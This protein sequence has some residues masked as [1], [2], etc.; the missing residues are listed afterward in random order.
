MKT[1]MAVAIAFV[2]L[3][4]LPFVAQPAAAG[5]IAIP[6]DT[7]VVET[8]TTA[9]YDGG[10]WVHVRIGDVSLGVIWSTNASLRRGP[11]LFLDYARFFGA[12]ELYDEQG[13]YLGTRALPMHTVLMQHF[14]KMV[15]FVDVDG[16][17]LFDLHIENRTYTSGD[18]PVKVLDLNTAWALDG[19]IEQVV[20]NTSAWVSFTIRATNVSYRAVWDD[21]LHAWRP[22]TPSDGALD[23]VSL[24]FRLAATARD[25]I[26][27]VPVY[28]VTLANGD[29]RRTPTHS[30]FLENRT[31]AGRSV[32]IDGKYDQR[33]EGWDFTG[34]PDAKLAM[35]TPLSFGNFYGTLIVQWLQQQFG[36]ACLKDGTFEHCESDAG[37]TIPVRIA[38]DRLRVAEG[39]QRTT[40][41][42]E[43]Y[44]TSDVTVDGTPAT[45]T[46]EIY[47]AER[48]AINRGDAVFTGFRALGGFVYPQG[49]VIVHDPG[50]SATSAL[51][52]IVET[53]NV[54]PSLLVGLQV[55]V[56]GLALVPALLLRK[57]LRK[58]SP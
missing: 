51:A 35:V 31:Y 5:R 45:M 50:L 58:G 30:E 38:R 55:A 2:A 18:H 17:G 23:R 27:T 3:L 57:K 49:Q 19:A 32:A 15:E 26:V 1:A 43:T 47:G 56:V 39:W 24:T 52:A 33:I 6:R 7:P 54:A 36:G 21:V 22:A 29:E 14:D 4:A 40:D 12:A 46:F 16:D 20:T 10:Q 25:G 8:G 48:F 13:N 28:K 44:W 34:G 37:P 9:R 41:A 11:A 42:G 53:R